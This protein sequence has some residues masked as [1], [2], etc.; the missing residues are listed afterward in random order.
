M[1]SSTLEQHNGRL[2]VTGKISHRGHSAPLASVPSSVIIVGGGAAGFAAVEMIRR[3]K[4][5]QPVTMMMDD[6]DAR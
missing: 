3:Q 2:F 5:Q 4:Y 6:H 1:S